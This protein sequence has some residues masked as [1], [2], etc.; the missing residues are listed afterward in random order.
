MTLARGSIIAML[1]STLLVWLP[2]GIG[3]LVLAHVAGAL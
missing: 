3:L 1:L 2:L